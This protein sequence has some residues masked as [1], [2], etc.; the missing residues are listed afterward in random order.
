MIYYDVTEANPRSKLPQDCIEY[1]EKFDNLEQITGCD[2][3]ILPE[4]S[5]YE[6]V[7]ALLKIEMTFVKIAEALNLSL[8]DVINL[9][10][11]DAEKVL[12]E[13][14]FA[15]AILVQRKSG[16]DFLNSLGPRL[17]N[18]IAKMC[19]V[20]PKQH[21]RM[22][23]VT[24]V[25]SKK[26]DDLT[27]NG[28]RTSYKYAQYRSAKE[29]VYKKGACISF[30]PTDKDILDWIKC[31][32]KQLLKYKH[33]DLKWIVSP[34]YYAP[35]VPD[36]DDPLQLM[37]PVR[38]ARRSIINIPG[39]GINKVNSLQEYVKDVLQIDYRPSLFSL[40]QYATSPETAKH[41]KGIGTGLIDNARKYV[42]LADSEYLWK[43][44]GNIT[45]QKGETTK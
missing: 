5:N 38:D 6:E 24:G 34:V 2:F 22:I 1:G 30:E 20:A 44:H 14:L 3:V 18:S 7:Q 19:E 11:K 17:N 8:M 9:S 13:W 40:L 37:K 35:D 25:F 33:T 16:H 41:L 26:G 32:E 42:G 21:Q 28:K 15:G 29:A 12:H 10:N 23:L 27:L 31:Q 45:V 43:T 4:K 36:M 39:W